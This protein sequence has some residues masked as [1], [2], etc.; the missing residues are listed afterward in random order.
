MKTSTVAIEIEGS[1]D[2]L[3]PTNGA[4]RKE[5]WQLDVIATTQAARNEMD[6]LLAN[7]AP[8]SLRLPGTG[9]AGLTAGFYSV[10]DVD[11]ER[12]GHPAYDHVTV[13]SL[14]L[15]PNRAPVFKPL[16]Q[17]TLDS[18]PQTYATMDEVLATYATMND[19]LVGP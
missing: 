5:T 10:G 4:R 15:T 18:V 2:Y 14:P 9:Y 8:L 7:D 17:W 12:I 11:P 16:N 6:A 3:T 1:S 19:L 13:F